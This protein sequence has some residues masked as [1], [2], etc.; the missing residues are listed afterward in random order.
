MSNSFK[1]CQTHFSKRV[2]NFSRRAKPPV[3][4]LVTGL[5]TKYI[6]ST[7]RF[8]ISSSSQVFNTRSCKEGKYVKYNTT[9]RA[10][11]LVQFAKGAAGRRFPT[12][13]LKHPVTCAKS[14]PHLE[15]IFGR[16]FD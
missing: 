16:I 1:I 15:L 14:L 10:I 2:N 9:M 8:L 3:C 6:Y 11:Q 12:P 13:V 4:P 7:V 5:D